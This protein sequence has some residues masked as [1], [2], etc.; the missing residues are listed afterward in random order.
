MQQ[1]GNARM[2]VGGDTGDGDGT[3]SGRVVGPARNN[4]SDW[5]SLFFIQP[6]SLPDPH[7]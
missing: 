2:A 1:Q 5:E 4:F 6:A 7:A 3:G